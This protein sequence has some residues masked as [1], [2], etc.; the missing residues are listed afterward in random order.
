[1]GQNNINE[2]TLEARINSVLRTAFPSF[3]ELKVKH[4]DSFSI[5]FG[6]HN[7]LV[8]LKEPSIYPSRAIF[9]ILLT[10]EDEKNNL[11]LLELKREGNNITSDDIE[12]GLSYARLIHP[13]PPITLISNGSDNQ[14]YDTYSKQKLDRDNVDMDFLMNRIDVAFELALNDLK[15]TAEVLLGKE[16]RVFTQVV[17]RISHDRFES[18]KGELS[19]LTRP[20]CENF[21]LSR[22][23]I[24]QLHD[25]SDKK[26]LVGLIGHA[27]SG[28][29]NL[30]YDFFR[31]YSSDENTCYYIDCNQLNYSIFRQ[32][33]NHLTKECRFQITEDKIRDWIISYLVGTDEVKF[34]FLI[35]N[36]DINTAQVLKKEVAELIELL[37]GSKH[38]II[39]TMNQIS[40]NRISKDN[41]RNYKTIFGNETH[42][43]SITEF[44]AEEF[45]NAEELLRDTC[46]VKFEH[47]AHFSSEYRQPRTL[48]LIASLFSN[49]TEKMP[50]G[51]VFKMMAVP[52]FE[53][54][55]IL[56]QNSSFGSGMKGVF[57]RLAQAFLSD[58]SKNKTP[59]LQLAHHY[60]GISYPEVANFM[61]GGMEE[62]LQSGF[63]VKHELKDD[64]AIIYPKIPELVALY[65]VDLI[66]S[67]LLNEYSDKSIDEAYNYLEKSCSSLPYGD[68]VATG[69]LLKIAG[70][71]E[72]ELFSDLVLHQLSLEPQK[73]KISD[74]TKARM[75]IN[76][77]M[78]VDIEFQGDEFEEDFISNHFPFL[79]LSQLAGYPLQSQGSNEDEEY[80]FYLKL[81]YQLTRNGT[82]MVRVPSFSFENTPPVECFEL[83]NTGTILLGGNGIIEP[84]V[85]SIQK[86]FRQIPE[87][88]MRLAE[89]AFENNYFPVIWRIYLAL[90]E[91]T[92]IVDEKLSSIATTFIDRFN[93]EFPELYK[94]LLL[95]NSNSEITND[96]NSNN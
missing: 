73:Q 58:I 74:G 8:D 71:G 50:E 72:V 56:S 36:F 66:S 42:T 21:I 96:K 60:G 39:F 30:L 81:L 94:R 70:S 13:M 83:S 22:S 79:V 45:R 92:N 64:V 14:F 16:P 18:F 34:T 90:R 87:Q 88:I 10:T 76:N 4:Q 69:V 2:A 23:Y 37:K 1:M 9:D 19:D 57:K 82:S 78:V 48:R 77:K 43:L 28:K 12:Q 95:E 5:K 51:Q 3:E 7:V 49:Q 32:L 6:H 40:Y 93:S 53:F 11:I 38:S 59:E 86:S 85:Q 80:D 17:N 67:E 46:R 65:S 27:F 41:F 31:T 52:D 84:L 15:E 61:E 91:E 68:I 89:F 33:S 47:G 35:D 24:E 44:S 29:T 54:L 55:K 20:I 63:I 75:L 62:L 25:L 26:N